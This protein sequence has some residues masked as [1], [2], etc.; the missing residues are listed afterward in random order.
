M[1]NPVRSEGIYQS[2]IEGEFFQREILHFAFGPSSLSDIRRNPRFANR[3]IPLWLPIGQGQE[4]FNAGKNWRFSVQKRKI[5]IRL[6]MCYFY[7]ILRIKVSNIKTN[8]NVNCISSFI[9]SHH[10][11]SSFI[12]IHHNITD[13]HTQPPWYRI[14]K[15]MTREERMLC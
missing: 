15:R 4:C 3:S 9:F 8:G 5:L 10:H 13:H 7:V 1:I 14:W 2:A 12:A 6:R 11:T